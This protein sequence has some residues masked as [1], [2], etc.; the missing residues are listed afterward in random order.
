[1]KRTY[2]IAGDGTRFVEETVSRRRRNKIISIACLIAA[3]PFMIAA[4]VG[5]FLGATGQIAAEV[6]ASPAASSSPAINLDKAKR[7][8]KKAP[9]GSEGNCL[10]LY[11]RQA[12]YTKS[13]YTPKGSAL[14]K[15]CFDQYRGQE[16]AWCLDQE[17]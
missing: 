8:C 10:E 15:E 2:I 14:V 17:I 13:T 7:A 1:M 11:M 12:W 3:S 9:K 16:L 6:K 4:F 5:I